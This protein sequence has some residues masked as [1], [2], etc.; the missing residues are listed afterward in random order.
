MNSKLKKLML[1][2]AFVWTVTNFHHPVTPSHFTTLNMPN[3]I[4]GTSFAMMVFTSFL[5]SP[6]WGSWGDRNSR[7]KVLSLSTLLYGIGQLG[8]ALSTSLG[9]ILFFR[10]ISGIANGGFSGGLMAAIVDTTTDEN[11]SLTMSRYSAMMLICASL[12]FLIGGVL[13]FLPPQNVILMQAVTMFLV[14][15][16]FRFIVGETNLNPKESSDK[17]VMFIWDILR[18]AT[19]SKE[20]FTK[21]MIIFLGLTFFINI[22][23]SS[24]VNAFNYYL[25]EQLDFK[26]IV[27]G[28]WKAATG[29]VGF[30]ANMTI[31]AWIF[32]KKDVKRSLVGILLLAS[33]TSIMILLNPS[34]AQFMIWNLIFFTLIT[35]LIPILQ[36]YA[37]QG[38]AKEAG[39]MSGIYNA[40][41][42]LG[43]VVGS[44]V[45]GFAYNISSMA[46]FALATAALIIA[47][48]L[49]I[50]GNRKNI[51]SPL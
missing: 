11:R 48:M 18:D 50:V 9:G 39:L 7:M 36:N 14:S 29:V 15:L 12:G 17:K 51:E 27:N 44:M 41:R 24:N 45:A 37:V 1:F 40:I 13:G 43:E 26:P 6:I 3:H 34:V 28:M 38:N 16:G 30:T 31:N 20:I 2:S 32:K 25:K 4:F 19:K 21:W 46:P 49:A 33:L 23:N 8:F 47:F 22:A 10:G 42:A 5:T 35:V